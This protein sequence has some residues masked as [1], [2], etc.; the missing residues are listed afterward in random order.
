MLTNIIT[1][2]SFSQRLPSCHRPHVRRIVHVLPQP[3]RQGRARREGARELG[4]VP[5][6]HLVAFV[7]F[8]SVRPCHFS[9][10]SVRPCHLL[11]F[12]FLVKGGFRVFN[13]LI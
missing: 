13:V 12:F 6:Y 5:L 3:K 2:H 10:P 11:G 8:P 1:F 7:F 4:F 9:H